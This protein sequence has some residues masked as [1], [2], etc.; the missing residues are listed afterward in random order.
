MLDVQCTTDEDVT[1]GTT[2]HAEAVEVQFDPEITSPAILFDVFFQIH[3]PT[4]RNRQ[5][6][7]VGTQYRSA[8]W[9]STPTQRDAFERL[10]ETR[11]IDHSSPITTELHNLADATFHPAEDYHQQYLEKGGQT[12]DK[13]D[14]SPVQCYGSRG[15][16]KTLD[17][18]RLRDHFALLPRTNDL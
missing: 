3:D 6:G 9:Y 13:G 1:T 10:R 18:P 16:I 5:G 7:D 4:T 12:A 17:K 14:L 8:V 15:P 11:A 2:G